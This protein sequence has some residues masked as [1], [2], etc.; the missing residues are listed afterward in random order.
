[1]NREWVK[2]LSDSNFRVVVSL[3]FDNPFIEKSI[4][5]EQSGLSTQ[6]LEKALKELV[7]AMVILELASQADSSMESRVPKKIY[8]VNPEME[9]EIKGLR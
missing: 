7:D 1:M 6:E 9:E 3:V 4:L 2:M 8:L 5:A